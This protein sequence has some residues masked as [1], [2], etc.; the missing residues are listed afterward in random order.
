MAESMIRF[1]SNLARMKLIPRSGWISHGVSL[2]DIES[3]ADHS[4]STSA[5]SLLIADLE[6]QGG[7]HVNVERVL[8]LAILHDLSESLT[9]DISKEYLEYLGERGEVI[10]AELE[11]AAW[12]HIM[13]GL[14]GPTLR[15]S[16]LALQK[17]FDAEQTLEAKIVHAAD[18]IDI[19]LQVIQ[20]RRKGYPAASLADLW[21]GTNSKLRFSRVASARRIQQ[22]LIR[23]GRRL[24]TGNVK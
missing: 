21:T 11:H 19:L 18:R 3:V 12:K 2:Q 1:L 17:E 8:R 24:G 10:K 7:K 23:E 20:Y 13:D 9:F 4:F 14:E 6:V 15:R 22:V 16:Y 5:L